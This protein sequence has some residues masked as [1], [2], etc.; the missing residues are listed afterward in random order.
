MNIKV[1]SRKVKKGDIFVAL[2]ETKENK[3]I[4]IKQAIDKGAS[5]IICNEG[6]YEVETINVEDPKEYLT[7]YL[8]KNYYSKLSKL[9]L[10]GITGTNG[11]T[12][13]S[14]LIYQALNK[15][16]KKC[17]YI[18]TIG[19]YLNETIRTLNNT[20]PDIL[21]LYEL[22]LECVDNNIEYVVMEVSS[23]GLAQKRVDSLLFDYAI[24]TNLTR[25]HLD[26][27][28]TMEE[29]A[30][31]KKKLFNKL[32]NNGYR[33]INVDDEYS[34]LFLTKDAITYG[35]NNSDYQILK[36]K[37]AQTYTKFQIKKNNKIYKYK[38]KLTGRYNIYNLLITIIIL[39]LL[40]IKDINKIIKQL[41]P[42]PG[43]M[44]KIIFNKNLV[45]IDY[46]HSPDA[47]LNVIKATRMLT[48]KRIITLIGCGGNRDKTKRKEMAEI[49][50]KYSDFS[51]FTNDN[52]RDED[53]K[54]ILNGMTDKLNYE[55]YILLPN[56][57]KAIIQ[58][59]KTLRKKDIFL[60]LG[61]GHED[62][63]IIKNEKKHF[64]DK[65]EVLKYIKNNK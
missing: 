33:I 43:R 11:K 29:Y 57:K 16:N 26:F 52:P 25:D 35:F 62:Y 36:Y 23:H 50:C 37:T 45:I 61:K 48:S 59:M 22:L 20:T 24:F 44:D 40:K 17:A 56:R 4:Y 9:K 38:S 14:Y 21:D 31:E 1:D 5:K 7:S 2:K 19:F 6:E 18:G 53:P 46:A 34:D 12:T 32:N 39:E 28:K 51:I 64:S 49:A 58:G 54:Q 41:E 63:Q 8:F 60:I 15:L 47:V 13:T 42:P 10:I 3:E 55:N 30:K 65:E 27:H